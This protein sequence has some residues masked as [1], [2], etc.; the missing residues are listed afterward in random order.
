VSEGSDERWDRTEWTVVGTLAVAV[1]VYVGAS[2]ATFL[3]LPG[4][5]AVAGAASGVLWLSMSAWLLLVYSGGT[6]RLRAAGT[7]GFL[8]AGLAEL[9]APFAAAGLTD[10]ATTA[11]LLVA[12]AVL[13]L[14]LVR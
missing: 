11:G 4:A 7:A 2:V 9:A 8:V 10:V 1:V 14:D 12:T 13:L 3:T 5:A 6:A